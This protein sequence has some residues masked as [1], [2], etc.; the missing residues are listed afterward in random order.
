MA[1]LETERQC[2]VEEMNVF[3]SEKMVTEEHMTRQITDHRTEVVKLE[4]V[5]FDKNT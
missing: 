3:K 5:S 2:L 4:E 1:D